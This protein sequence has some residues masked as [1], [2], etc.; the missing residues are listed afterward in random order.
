MPN[1][2]KNNNMSNQNNLNNDLIDLKIHP[3]LWYNWSNL[4]ETKLYFQYLRDKIS[5]EAHYMA[6][7]I[8]NGI[9]IEDKTTLD[10]LS[11][12]GLAIRQLLEIDSSQINDFYQNRSKP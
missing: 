11:M 9:M 12:L 6:N 7:N 4:P 8:M 5:E 1:N 10:K 3:E 2:L